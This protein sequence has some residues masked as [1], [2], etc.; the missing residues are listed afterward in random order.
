MHEA[1]LSSKET[2]IY[3]H[4]CETLPIVQFGPILLLSQLLETHYTASHSINMPRGHGPVSKI[5]GG[6]IGIGQEAYAH[7]KQSKENQAEIAKAQGARPPPEETQ[8]PHDL[9][10]DDNSSSYDGDHE[11]WELDDAQH[12]DTKSDEDEDLRDTDKLIEK[13]FKNHPPTQQVI[14]HGNLELP[15]IIPQ[16]RPSHKTRG[17]VRAYAPELQTVGVDENTFLDFIDGM[18]NAIKVSNSYRLPHTFPCRTYF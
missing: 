2:S 8:P 7:H 9:S 15:V 4:Y 10:S 16:R 3:K 13:F 14:E 18:G 11:Q 5:V 1:S 6:A 17:F 12:E